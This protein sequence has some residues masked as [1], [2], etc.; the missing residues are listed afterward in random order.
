[1]QKLKIQENLQKIKSHK[2]TS[3]GQVTR[4]QQEKRKQLENEE[5]FQKLMFR[6][7]QK[8]D[9]QPHQ[10][11]RGTAKFGFTVEDVDKSPSKQDE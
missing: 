8:E 3:K 5:Q 2:P 9:P 7:T 6:P 4:E 1:M 11:F 10:D